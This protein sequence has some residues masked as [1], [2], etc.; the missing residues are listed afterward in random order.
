MAAET[1]LTTLRDCEYLASHPRVKRRLSGIDITFTDSGLS[2]TRG[3]RQFGVL[4]WESVHDLSAASW[5]TVETHITAPRVLLLG[6]FWAMLFRKRTQYAH[7]IVADGE[8]EWVFA[9]P[10]IAAADLRSGLEPLRDYL[11]DH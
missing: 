11:P 1:I 10:G 9:V 8:G 2:L 3:R 7:L 6:W 5:E 4:P